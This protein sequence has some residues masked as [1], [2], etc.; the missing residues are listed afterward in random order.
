MAEE[1]GARMETGEER[2]GSS[3]AAS[4]Q[5]DKYSDRF[6]PTRA[7]S[8]AGSLSLRDSLGSANCTNAHTA[9]DNREDTSAA[10]TSALRAELFGEQQPSPS[11]VSPLHVP[12]NPSASASPASPSA[13]AATTGSRASSLQGRNA[14]S[15]SPSS[16]QRSLLHWRNGT[17][18]AS[19]SAAGSPYSLSPVGSDPCAAPYGTGRRTHRRVARSPFKVLDAPSLCDDFYLNLLDWSSSNLL[20]VGL[21]RSVY[22]WNGYTSRVTQL[23][24][25]NSDDAVCSV[26]WTKRGNTLAVGTSFGQV[27][28]WDV[29]KQALIRALTGHRSRSGCLAWSGNTLTSGSKDRSILMR[30]IRAPE[31]FVRQLN[32]HRSE[33]CGL[34]WSPD[35]RELASGGNDNHL[36]IWNKHSS[37]PVLRFQEHNAAV[38]AIAWSPHQ[39]GVLASGGGT[40]DRCI[41]FWNTASGVPLSCIDTGSQV[42]NVEWSK[43]VNELVSTHGYS[44][45]QVVVW[46]YPSMSKV[47]TL[48]GHTL[49][50]LYLSISPDGETIVTGAG[51]ETLRFW[52]VFPSSRPSSNEKQHSALTA[53]TSTC[54]R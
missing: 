30:D 38:K 14:G 12:N 24:E 53:S 51:D 32:G 34:K 7:G 28:V 26:S 27:H 35:E 48:T 1:A 31:P 29:E 25:V 47:A 50:V 21:E 44:Q 18:P 49:R 6:I 5:N 22:I 17:G 4:P 33:V 43:N 3:T 9:A 37:N 41:R 54:I 10:Y 13:T 20:A 45:N 8:F 2:R 15:A 40:A 46:R 52:S 39:H 23:C 16:P 42:C 19:P 36:V 11:R